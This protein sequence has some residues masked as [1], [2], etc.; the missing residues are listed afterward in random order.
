MANNQTKR[1]ELLREFEGTSLT[2]FTIDGKEYHDLIGTLS[3]GDL[4]RPKL[5]KKYNRLKYSASI[6]FDSEDSPVAKELKKLNKMNKVRRSFGDVKDL[7]T[8]EMTGQVYFTL[9]ANVF[10]DEAGNISSPLTVVDKFGRTQHQ[11][12][13]RGSIVKVRFFHRQGKNPNDGSETHSWSLHGVQVLKL[14]PY[15]SPDVKAAIFE[16]VADDP[17]VKEEQSLP[18]NAAF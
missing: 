18:N 13:A 3:Y 15:E 7:G 16:P 10:K 9:D 11:I 17:E 14:I 6:L 12:P 2:S 5:D 4:M 8:G 1:N